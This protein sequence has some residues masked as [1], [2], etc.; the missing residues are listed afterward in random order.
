MYV[1]FEVARLQQ[2]DKYGKTHT[3]YQVVKPETAPEVQEP[4]PTKKSKGKAKPQSADI[5]F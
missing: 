5:P 4:A 2:A 3:V 1:S